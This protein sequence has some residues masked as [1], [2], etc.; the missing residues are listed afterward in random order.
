MAAQRRVCL[1]PAGPRRTTAIEGKLWAT[2]HVGGFNK[3]CYEKVSKA[4]ARADQPTTAAGI[5][6]MARF[7]AQARQQK[8]DLAEHPDVARPETHG[9]HFDAVDAGLDSSPVVSVSRDQQGGS[10]RPRGLTELA[11]TG[12]GLQQ[13]RATATTGVWLPRF[14]G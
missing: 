13:A 3:A 1:R 2:Q 4:C 12:P 11:E 6:W 14:T 8:G 9:P 10:E 5:P 7:I